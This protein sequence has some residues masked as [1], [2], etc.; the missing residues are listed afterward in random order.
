MALPTACLLSMPS[1]PIPRPASLRRNS[2]RRAALAAQALINPTTG[3]YPLPN[4]VPTQTGDNYQATFPGTSDS[5]QISVRYNESFGAAPTR[6][7]GGFGG[8]GLRGANRNAPP[9]LRQSI[10]ENFAESHSA[11][12]NSS[13]SPQLGGKSV[14]NGY[15]LSSGYTVGYGRINSTAT[16]SWNR[17]LSQ[18]TNYFTD[19]TVNPAQT[20]GINIGNSQIY[21]NKFF[22]GVPSIS[23]GGGYQGLGD[24]TPS[25]TVNQTISFSDFVSWT[26]KRHNMRYGVDF[27][28]IHADSIGGTN[29]LGSFTFSNY[30]TGLDGTGQN[31][32]VALRTS[33]IR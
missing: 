9:V 25:T 8:G 7:R 19:G 3:Y 26:H 16:L 21:D 31:C 1:I 4:I 22:Y 18:A 30:N 11:S 15:S 5:S 33:L 32:R 20:A 17:S 2:R 6:G 23:I 27:H 10:A 24:A 12:A 14:S 13:F 28:R 29:A